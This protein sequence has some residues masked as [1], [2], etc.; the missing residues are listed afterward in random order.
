MSFE[1]PSNVSRSTSQD[2]VIHV[3]SF[4]KAQYPRFSLRL[5]LTTLFSSENH[6]LK[7]KTRMFLSDDGA[8]ELMDIW[9]T[10]LKEEP[11]FQCWVVDHAALIC[12]KECSR[13]SDRASEGPHYADAQFLRI[14]P[15]DVTVNLVESFRFDDLTKRYDRT[16]PHLQTIL[17]KVIGKEGTHSTEAEAVQEARYGRTSITSMILN[18]RSRLLSYHPTINSF[19]LWDSQV[20]KR[21]VQLLNKIGWSVS[22]TSQGRCISQLSQDAVRVARDVACDESK[23]KLLPYDN[24]NWTARAWEVSATHGA[25]QHDQVSAMLVV[26]NRP[27]TSESSPGAASAQHL[28]SVERFESTAGHRHRLSPEDALQA[29]IPDHN[30]HQ[31]FRTRA[32]IHISHISSQR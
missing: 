9:W 12:D 17:R 1:N 30:D 19:V 16:T 5:F 8:L 25:A 6:T 14:S 21:I 28:A 15:K 27:D 3:L 4:M 32:S 26:L 11:N 10:Q 23:L 29:V 31:S 24:F 20:P 18:Q 7:Q 13:L 22:H 2:K